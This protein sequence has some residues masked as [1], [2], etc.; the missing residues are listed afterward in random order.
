MTRFLIVRLGALG[1]IV[2]AIPVAA[3]LRRARPAARIDWMVSC[4]HRDI[5][6]LVPPIDE[7]LSIKDRS[8]PDDGESL[9][10]ALQ[11]IRKTRYDVTI[12]L[13]GLLKSAVIARLSGA[14]KVVGFNGK[15]SRE[16]MARAFYTDVYDPGGD[17]MYAPSETRH[18]VDIN[19][20]ML[21][22][23]GIDP[24]RPEFPL[25]D[26]HSEVAASMTEAAGGSYVLL[27]PGAAWPNKRWP[28]PRL[29]ALAIALRARRNLKSVVLWGPGEFD[30]AQ[31][32]VA[33]AG[34]AAVL[35]PQTSVADVVAL[36]R[37]AAVMVSGDTGP[38][39][40]A[41]A[42][43]TP[44]VGIYGPTRPERNG[45]WVPDD[46]TVSRA[47]ICQCHH[48]R[49]C[50]IERMCLLDIEVDE[51]LAAVERRLSAAERRRA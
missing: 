43:G 36:A 8:G 21:K 10:S 37:G 34:G 45:P 15:Y 5:L 28:P 32:V 38:T 35:S 9:W 3:A 50:K 13:Q 26:V 49:Q 22:A 18:V 11:R 17:G 29:G 30:L 46:E 27:N 24:G 1:D 19:L 42:V 20:G 41:A 33:T 44:I 2:H 31:D 47:S 40:I 48:F 12:D 39:H 7:R 16:S 14:G 23:I 25:A 6:D 4:K 51:V